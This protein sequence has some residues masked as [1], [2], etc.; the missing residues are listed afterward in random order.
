MKTVNTKDYADQLLAELG[1]DEAIPSKKP[2][3]DEVAVSVIRFHKVPH[4]DSQ[5]Q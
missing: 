1:M 5:R 4:N 2:R 3:L